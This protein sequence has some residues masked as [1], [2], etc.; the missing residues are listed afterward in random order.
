MNINALGIGSKCEYCFDGRETLKVVYDI[1][2]E[3]LEV[4]FDERVRPIAMMV[5][6]LQMPYKN[7]VQIVQDMQKF[8]D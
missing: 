4:P 5:L 8:Y 2:N 1:L 7:G 3:A 6:D